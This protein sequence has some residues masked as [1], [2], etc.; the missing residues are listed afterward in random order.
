MEAK[1][2]AL[3][4]TIRMAPPGVIGSNLNLAA[5]HQSSVKRK[6]VRRFSRVT[7]CVFT[8]N[9]ISSPGT[10]FGFW[11]TYA[12]SGNFLDRAGS[13]PEASPLKS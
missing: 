8:R 6:S 2:G 9:V 11:V 12:K 1:R 5:A 10:G 7:E 4:R 13:P 3:F